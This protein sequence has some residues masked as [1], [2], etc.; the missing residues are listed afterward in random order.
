MITA[1]RHQAPPYPYNI[2]HGDG[3]SYG[4]NKGGSSRRSPH[5]F[6]SSLGGDNSYV[7]LTSLLSDGFGKGRAL[8]RDFRGCT[9]LACV[10]PNDL[11]AVVINA[12]ARMEP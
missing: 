12:I 2:G 8:Y 6:F 9:I 10:Y 7:T 11:R 3:F 5:H 4:D 1:N